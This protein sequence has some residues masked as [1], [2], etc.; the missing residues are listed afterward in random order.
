M[1]DNMTMSRHGR[2]QRALTG[3]PLDERT[4][5][6]LEAIA[7]AARITVAGTGKDGYVT[8]DDLRT[9]IR[10]HAAPVH[11]TTRG[12]DPVTTTEE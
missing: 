3:R 5:A 7:D 12:S 8:A 10:D 1:D 9:A 11:T 2:L 4:R 6:E